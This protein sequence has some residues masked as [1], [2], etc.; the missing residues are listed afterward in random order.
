M[1]KLKLNDHR[2]YPRTKVQWPGV[3]KYRDHIIEVTTVDISVQGVMVVSSFKV[4]TNQH[5]TLMLNCSFNDKK[6]VFYAKTR[7]KQVR[8]SQYK[9]NLILI[10]EELS[11]KFKAFIKNFV[12]ASQNF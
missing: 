11:P 9:F 12:S 3:I 7:V 4:K 6:A 5:A 10:F 8:F 1:E 2:R